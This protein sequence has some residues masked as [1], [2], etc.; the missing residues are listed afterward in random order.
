[1]KART[2]EELDFIRKSGQISAVAL[3]KGLSKAE[4]GANLLDI[5]RVVREA[6][7]EGGSVRCSRS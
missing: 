1:M 6:I 5:E 4:I 7:E 3:K 2:K